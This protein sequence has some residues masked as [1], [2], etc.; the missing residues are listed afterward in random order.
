MNQAAQ[1]NPDPVAASGL[2]ALGDGFVSPSRIALCVG[3]V[4]QPQARSSCALPSA[5]WSHTAASYRNRPLSCNCSVHLDRC[6][7]VRHELLSLIELPIDVDVSAVRIECLPQNR[8]GE[9]S[10]IDNLD[11]SP[12][13]RDR[14]RSHKCKPGS[15]G[16]TIPSALIHFTKQQS[17]A[18]HA[19]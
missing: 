14:H 9:P 18:L 13:I 8:C 16:Q 10:K 15:Y 12:M 17:V 6:T 19:G 11:P 4:V 2:Q 1:V 3:V 5:S 7:D